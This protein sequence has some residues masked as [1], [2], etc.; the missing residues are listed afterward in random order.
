[1]KCQMRAGLP[2]K[3]P[4]K[5]PKHQLNSNKSLGSSCTRS[6]FLT[7]NALRYHISLQQYPSFTTIAIQC[8]TKGRS[9]IVELF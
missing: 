8:G 3:F 9:L 4:E 7:R 1:M 2:K 5:A 6:Q